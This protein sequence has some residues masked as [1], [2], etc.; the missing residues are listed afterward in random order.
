MCKIFKKSVLI[1]ESMKN[2]DKLKV[3]FES[4]SL[5]STHLQ[6]CQKGLFVGI[7]C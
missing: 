3:L 4:Y 1:V 5:A 2:A 6:K 7:T